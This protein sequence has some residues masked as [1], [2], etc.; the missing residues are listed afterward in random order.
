MSSFPCCWGEERP[1]A[2]VGEEMQEGSEEEEMREAEE[3]M[4]GVGEVAMKGE[5]VE[6]QEWMEDRG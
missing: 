5:V 1:Q 2:V 3:Q 6:E 4:W